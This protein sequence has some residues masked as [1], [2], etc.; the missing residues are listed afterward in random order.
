MFWDDLN[1]YYQALLFNSFVVHIVEC[2]GD[3]LKIFPYGLCYQP[4]FLPHT[5]GYE[6]TYRLAGPMSA[7][8]SRCPYW[9]EKAAIL[10]KTAPINNSSTILGVD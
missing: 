9:R 10:A 6:P 1:F 8:A 5:R 4:S 2:P 7:P 3:P